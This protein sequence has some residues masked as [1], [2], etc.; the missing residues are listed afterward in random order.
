MASAPHTCQ[1][2]Q[3]LMPELAAMVIL[4]TSTP[5]LSLSIIDYNF[6]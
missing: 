1:L 4:Q 3:K 5:A 6:I 2:S